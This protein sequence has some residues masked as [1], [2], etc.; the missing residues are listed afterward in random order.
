MYP[1]NTR[2]GVTTDTALRHR[3]RVT[4]ERVVEL[5]LGTALTLVVVVAISWGVD[6][7]YS[8]DG[9]LQF[10]GTLVGFG[11]AAAIYRR[12][13]VGL[14]GGLPYFGAVVGDVLVGW[15]GLEEPLGLAGAVGV[16]LLGGGALLL[17]R[18]S[19]LGE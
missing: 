8:S 5:L 12:H 10:A 16:A 19:F 3:L 2:A 14:L 1:G 18:G 4:D 7:Y 11:L 9:S 15:S 17:C 6:G 13:P